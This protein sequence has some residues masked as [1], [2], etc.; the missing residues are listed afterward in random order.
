MRRKNKWWVMA[1]D[2]QG[3]VKSE[4]LYEA[5]AAIDAGVS[6]EQFVADSS[7]AEVRA[8]VA[9]GV[10][11]A[12]EVYAAEVDGKRRATLLKQYAPADDV[13]SDDNE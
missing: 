2:D 11:S 9:E 4:A 3:T 5:D 7:V 1:A 12:E 6:V 8:L 13:D 10:L